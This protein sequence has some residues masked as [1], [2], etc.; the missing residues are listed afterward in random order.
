MKWIQPS[1]IA[2][3]IAMVAALQTEINNLKTQLAKMG[4]LDAKA[5]AAVKQFETDFFAKVRADEKAKLAQRAMQD[6]QRNRALRQGLNWLP[7]G[8]M[9][10]PVLWGEEP[11]KNANQ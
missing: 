5:A 11:K 2:L 3:L 4:S 1:V 8:D 7:T 10:K 9:N 6:A